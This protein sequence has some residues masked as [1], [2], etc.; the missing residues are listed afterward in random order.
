MAWIL[1]SDAVCRN[2]GG[3][4]FTGDEG[5]LVRLL[6]P[7]ERPG[8]IRL[9]GKSM[10]KH[11]SI[12]AVALAGSLQL[13]CAYGATSIPET[14][15]VLVSNSGAPETIVTPMSND[16]GGGTTRAVRNVEVAVDTQSDT[17]TS[18]A[19]TSNSGDERDRKNSTTDANA[20]SNSTT[21]AHKARGNAHWQSLLPGLM[22]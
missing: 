22:K 11:V 15:F 9:A 6:P 20:P 19:A 2:C 14:G 3:P 1:L 21:T 8:P 12:V 4:P 10:L 5:V 7:P 16:S 13:A 17:K 18:A